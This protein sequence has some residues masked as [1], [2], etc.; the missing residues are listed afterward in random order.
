MS[1]GARNVLFWVQNKVFR[2]ACTVFRL[3]WDVLGPAFAVLRLPS[4]C[5][6]LRS[7][8]SA[9]RATRLRLACAVFRSPWAIRRA[10]VHSS[11]RELPGLRVG[12]EPRPV[13]LLSSPRRGFKVERPARHSRTTTLAVWSRRRSGGS[14]SKKLARPG[15]L[16]NL[17]EDLR[18]E[19]VIDPEPPHASGRTLSQ[20]LIE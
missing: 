1:L 11:W 8:C 17:G 19:G 14:M 10:P 15:R 7:P 6:G 5:S 4:T 12:D 16:D 3:P 2:P 9:S 20:E 18:P 13:A